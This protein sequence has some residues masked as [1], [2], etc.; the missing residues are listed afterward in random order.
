MHHAVGSALINIQARRDSG[1]RELIDQVINVAFGIDDG[2]AVHC[3]VAMASLLDFIHEKQ[4]IRIFILNSD[5]SPANQH[6]ISDLFSSFAG[7]EIVYVHVDAEYFKSFSH[8]TSYISTA[9]YFRLKL[10]ALLPTDVEK[11]LYIDSDLVV[12][13]NIVGLW[14]EDI[15]DNY[16]GGI[17]DAQGRSHAGR[18]GF[19]PGQPYINAGVSAFNLKKIRAIDVDA[20][21]RETHDRHFDKITL[22]DQDIINIAFADAVAP[23]PTRWNAQAPLYNPAGYYASDDHVE[24]DQTAV[25]NPAIVHFTG[26]S[27]PWQAACTHPLRSIY[28]HYRKKIGWKLLPGQYYK[29]ALFSMVPEGDMVIIHVCFLRIVLHKKY[30]RWLYDLLKRG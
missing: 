20:L 10:Q 12:V 5:L 14:K 15:G 19:K 8:K 17:L 21:Y 11:V 16:I 27:K 28:L 22:Q 6:G 4:R 25:E 9:T 30:I 3:A 24:R 2:Y 18:L 29:T 7:L 26:K 13:D 23:L 1:K